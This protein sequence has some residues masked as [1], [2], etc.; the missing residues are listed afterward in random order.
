M[1]HFLMLTKNKYSGYFSL[2]A[3]QNVLFNLI[4]GYGQY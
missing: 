4:D 1:K 3:I 2:R